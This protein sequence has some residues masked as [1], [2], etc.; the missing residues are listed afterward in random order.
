MTKNYPLVIVQKSYLSCLTIQEAV[1]MSGIKVEAVCIGDYQE[2]RDY[3]NHRGKYQ[4]PNV[5]PPSII[6]IDLDMPGE[7]PFAALAEIKSNDNFRRIPIVALTSSD[8]LDIIAKSYELGV[9]SIIEKG[10]TLQELAE[11]MKVIH[12]YWYENVELPASR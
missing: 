8:S 2:L 3:L 6:M 4:S 1:A 12:Q 11:Q 5:L 9:N 10:H 7:D